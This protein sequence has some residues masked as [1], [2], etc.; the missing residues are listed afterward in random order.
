MEQKDWPVT[1]SIGVVSCSDQPFGV[2]E[3]INRADQVMYSVKKQGKNAIRINLA[4]NKH[5]LSKKQRDKK[6][7]M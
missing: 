5:R 3:I 6:R 1:F 7:R 2:D 4:L